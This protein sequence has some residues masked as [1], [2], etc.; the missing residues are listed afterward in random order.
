MYRASFAL[1]IV[2]LAAALLASTWRPYDTVRRAAVQI[3]P[4]D[5][6]GTLYCRELGNSSR[7]W[8]VRADG[9]SSQALPESVLGEPSHELH[10]GQRWFLAVES[11]GQADA[12]ELAAGALLLI[13]EQ[14]VR[15]PLCAGCD[16][17][18]SPYTAR[19]LRGTG[20]R[21]VAWIARRLGPRGDVLEGGIY[22]AQ[23]AFDSQ[24]VP[25][26]LLS[27]PDAP[28]VRIDLVQGAWPELRQALV[29]DACSFDCSPDGKSVVYETIGQRLF[30]GDLGGG[31]ARLL[32]D[33]RGCDPTWSFDG[34]MIL[35]KFCESFGAIASI[36]PDG[37]DLRECAWGREGESVVAY[38][39]FSPDARH[40]AYARGHARGPDDRFVLDVSID[41]LAGKQER[42][43]APGLPSQTVPVAWR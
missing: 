26:G 1:C 2:A 27:R 38:P 20:D 30:V 34:S 31:Q 9:T 21:T 35:F 11:A 5:Q 10:D 28:A 17:E 39:T 25:V 4:E 32:T 40:F 41:R 42:L 6:M 24:G 7:L 19:W 14:G 37:R 36:R 12:D 16:L 3:P 8:S 43:V 13:T 18:A 23:I 33:R 22:V 29:P 15:I